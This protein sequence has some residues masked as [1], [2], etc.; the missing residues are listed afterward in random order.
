MRVSE[1]PRWSALGF[2]ESGFCPDTL[3]IRRGGQRGQ[4]RW[5]GQTR[6]SCGASTAGNGPAGVRRAQVRTSEGAVNVERWEYQT[7]GVTRAHADNAQVRHID[8]RRVIN[9][10]SLFDEL[11]RAGLEGW[12]LVSTLPVGELR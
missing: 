12:E 2:E 5:T 10:R 4:T 6:V 7:W 11:E 1:P 8:G 3:A 9:S